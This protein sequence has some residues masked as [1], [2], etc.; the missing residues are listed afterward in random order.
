MPPFKDEHVLMI[1]PGS[2]TTLAQL[3]L[4]ESFTPARLRLPS[5]MFPAEKKGEWEPVKVRLKASA[6]AAEPEPIEK[7]NAATATV[8]TNGPGDDALDIEEEVLY[9]E[10]PTTDEGAVWPLQAGRIVNW[11][12]FFALLTHVYNT[13]SP[14]FHTPILVISQPAWTAHDHERLTQ[15][16]FE[17]FKTPAFCLMDSALAVCY[18]FATATATVIDVGHGKCD[19]TAVSDFVVNDLGRGAALPGCGGEG[20]TEHLRSLLDAKGFTK[21]MCE[22]LK[23]SSICEVLLPGTELPGT[24]LP[25]D[26]EMEDQIVNV[27]SAASAGANDPGAVQRGSIS[28]PGGIPQT[29]MEVD[30]VEEDLDREVKEGEENEGVLDVA[31]IV[32][33]GKTSEWVAKKE[34][35]KAEK[36]A[37]KKAASDAAAAAAPKLTRLPNSKR[38]KAI[39]H[40]HERRPLDDLNGNGKRATD[41]EGD[42]GEALK[43]QKTPPETAG[44]AAPDTGDNSASARKEDKRRS[45]DTVAYVRKDV[46]VGV[47]RFQATTGGIMDQIADAIHRCILSVPDISKRSELWDSLIIVG[48]GSKIK[49]FKEAL[50]GTLNAR[51]LISPSSAT[52]FTSELP[53]NLTTPVATGANTP[54]PQPHGPT[55]NPSHAHGPSVN[56]LLLAATTAS[57]HLAPPG[58]SQ[59]LQQYYQQQ[60]QSTN[61]ASN[62]VLLQQ[63]NSHGTAGGSG[64]HGHAQTPTSIKCAKMPEYFPEWKDAGTEE[65]GFLGAQVAAKVVFVVDQGL[66]KGFM[67]RTEYN[68]LGPIGVHECCL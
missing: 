55:P 26:H 32:A 41:T 59:Q 30:V 36:A 16:F 65:A 4:P 9:E 48:N 2:R 22:Q 54:Q 43:R 12:C 35:E 39:L 28:A 56:P 52:I 5:R 66:S 53:S 42:Q 64:T 23:R 15:F 58:H 18:A 13:L 1:V 40:Y 14:P 49:G 47:E 46:E 33:S 37:A 44:D 8:A 38:V 17:K 63:Q 51:Y 27:A 29:D 19:V 24:E 67:S 45:R 60:Q 34:K 68:E 61:T 3:G 31:S 10:D 21:D 62:A 20:M 6:N 11:S 57:N 7:R 25:E 50:L